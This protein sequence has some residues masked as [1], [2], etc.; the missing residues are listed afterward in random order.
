MVASACQMDD[1]VKA[2]SAFR[3]LRGGEQRARLM[4][5]CRKR[6]IDV[7]AKGD[8]PTAPELVRKA[9]QAL[10][11]GDAAAAVELA[12]TSNNMER[13]QEAIL[14]LGRAHCELEQVEDAR[15]LLRHLP[16][17][18]QPELETLCR[19]RGVEL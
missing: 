8:G 6:Q 18:A 5:S 10:E 4:V 12:R 1:G 13:T 7:R 16:V 11:S 19:E 17:E 15:A 14:L 3:K 2:R 9:K